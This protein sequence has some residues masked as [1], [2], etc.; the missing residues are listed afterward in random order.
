M[1]GSY[2]FQQSG[3]LLHWINILT[4][5]RN[6]HSFTCLQTWMLQKSAFLSA[7]G[8][9]SCTRCTDRGG[10]NSGCP[11]E[12][13]PGIYQSWC[14]PYK[15][16]PCIVQSNAMSGRKSKNPHFFVGILPSFTATAHFSQ[17]PTDQSASGLRA[18]NGYIVCYQQ[19]WL[20]HQPH[21]HWATLYL[22]L[23]HSLSQTVQDSRRAWNLQR[24]FTFKRPKPTSS[25]TAMRFCCQRNIFYNHFLTVAK[26]D[27]TLET[28]CRKGLFCFH[29]WMC[30]QPM[31]QCLAVDLC[32]FFLFG[33]VFFC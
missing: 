16:I 28:V 14:T 8:P 18:T 33:L 30:V 2:L 4:R 19:S 9:C 12:T 23:Q 17:C 6:H 15:P 24:P 11:S 5:G 21:M 27:Q 22:L 3:P 25:S 29:P 13:A 32:N 1:D 26:Q 31:L 10:Q 20:Q 7:A